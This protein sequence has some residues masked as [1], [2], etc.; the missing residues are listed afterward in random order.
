MFLAHPLALVAF[1]GFARPPLLTLHPFSRPSLLIAFALF[2]ARCVLRFAREAVAFGLLVAILLRAFGGIFPA[3]ARNDDPR[4]KHDRDH[5][6]RNPHAQ[7]IGVKQSL[8]HGEHRERGNR[9][10]FVPEATRS[11]W[12]DPV[13]VER[14]DDEQDEREGAEVL[15]RRWGCVREV[16]VHPRGAWP[17]P[18]RR[19]PAWASERGLVRQVYRP[20]RCQDDILDAPAI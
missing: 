5:C 2:F 6:K 12:Y 19:L 7:R 3:N 4:G 14:V 20:G 1:G 16:G 18:S 13:L 15:P 11:Q 8:E 17:D 10:I 9:H